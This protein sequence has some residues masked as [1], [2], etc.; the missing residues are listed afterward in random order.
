MGVP[1]LR[2]GRVIGVLV[3]QNRTMRHY[4]EEEVESLQTIAMVLA[5][6]VASEAPPEAKPDIEGR[7]PQASAPCWRKPAA[8]VFLAAAWPRA[9]HSAR[10][11]CMRRASISPIF[12]ASDLKAERALLDKALQ[13]LLKELEVMLSSDKLARAGEHRDVLEAYQMFAKDHGWTTGCARRW[14]PA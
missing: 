14:N 5:E 4:E 12:I 6:V 11:C 9:S 13:A 3:V 8:T 7:R 1:M 10:W 2:G